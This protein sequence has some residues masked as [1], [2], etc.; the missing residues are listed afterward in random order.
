MADLDDRHAH[1]RQGD[2]IALDL[3]EHG[4][5]QDSGPSREVEHAMNCCS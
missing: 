4:Y 2:E 3:L 5:W 1:T